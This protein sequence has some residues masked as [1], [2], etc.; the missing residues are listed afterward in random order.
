MCWA[1]VK[2]NEITG[3]RK[4]DAEIA[5]FNFTS[6]GRSYAEAHGVGQLGVIGVALFL[7]R[8]RS[9]LNTLPWIRNPR[10]RRAA[11]ARTPR[12]R[13][14]RAR[15]HPRRRI[16]RRAIAVERAPAENSHGA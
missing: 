3:W 9:I 15:S 11:A 12:A 8:P 13:H 6:A 4:S 7:E 10:S 5:A 16:C 2:L 1:R 14:R